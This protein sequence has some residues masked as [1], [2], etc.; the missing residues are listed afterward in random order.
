MRKFR[1]LLATVAAGFTCSAP[2]E[3]V[4]A[5]KAVVHDS[6]VT[7]EEVEAYT[8]PAEEA[9]RNRYR[10]QPEVYERELLKTL[11]ENLEERL[12]RQLILHE[13]KSGGYNIPAPILDSA[14]EEEI[15]RRGGR[16][17]LL[18]TLQARGMTYEKFRQQT[19]E[20]IILGAL[21]SKNISQE[22][23]ISPHRIER[24]YLANQDDYRLDN[25]VK[26]RR[27]ML[28]NTSDGR[29]AGATRLLAE[30]I[31][32]KIQTGAAFSEMA[33][34]YSAS[35][36]AKNGGLWG[37]IEPSG[38]NTNIAA[39]I[40]AL[41]TGEVSPPI[42]LGNAHY[43]FLLEEKRTAHHRPLNEVRDEIEANLVKEE[44]DRLEKQWIER[45]K[46]KT[47]IRYF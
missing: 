18:K 34:L 11:N 5:I 23:I 35:P 9:L 15:E 19:R 36:D 16:E 45:L 31:R 6:I 22:I 40:L 46:K 39:T 7:Q 2:A 38:I 14:V 27:I 47:F 12:K 42:E 24:Y 1:I 33:S 41:Q 28:N 13:F 21:R 10:T 17:R 3:L 8:A 4:N 29:D 26:L 30:E 32:T 25:Q 37:W 44:R 20:G 43:L